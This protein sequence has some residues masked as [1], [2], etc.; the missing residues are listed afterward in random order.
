MR[1]GKYDEIVTIQT[2]ARTSDSAGGGTI[3]WST[4]ARSWAN[5]REANGRELF[6][7]QQ[8]QNRTPMVVT[9]PD[10][11]SSKTYTPRMRIVRADGSTR[12]QI[13]A[14]RKAQR[15]Q[16]EIIFDCDWERAA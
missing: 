8:T 4:Y 10:V 15:Q 2:R 11:D 12:L 14:I 9:I 16:Q 13:K 6:A 3:A 5:V 1:T 7:Q